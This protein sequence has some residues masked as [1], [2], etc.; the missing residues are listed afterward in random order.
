MS[1]PRI[2][3]KPHPAM[4]VEF[5]KM[6]LVLRVNHMNRGA[7]EHN[8][9][10]HKVTEGTVRRIAPFEGK[11]RLSLATDTYGSTDERILAPGDALNVVLP[12]HVQW[13]RPRKPIH[14]AATPQTARVHNPSKRFES[15]TQRVLKQR[16][17]S[18]D[19]I[20]LRT[21]PAS[22]SQPRNANKS[23]ADFLESP[24]GVP[25]VM[26]RVFR[27]SRFQGN[28]KPR[29]FGRRCANRHEW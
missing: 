4:L 7:R 24:R 9:V 18:V 13:Q 2:L 26:Q 20:Q 27:S 29:R 19:A 14:L 12:E 22:T 21:G 17:A 25:L 6:R 11:H 15:A 16:I 28:A 1:L 3:G 23:S 5:G 8:D 10:G